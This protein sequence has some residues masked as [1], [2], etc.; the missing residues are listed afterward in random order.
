MGQK[1]KQGIQL[2]LE[3][4]VWGVQKNIY[5]RERRYLQSIPVLL[6]LLLLFGVGEIGKQYVIQREEG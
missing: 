5:N 6:L 1:W 4:P 2:G 3:V